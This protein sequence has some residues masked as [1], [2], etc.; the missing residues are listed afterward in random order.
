MNGM[1]T[2]DNANLWQPVEKYKFENNG[3]SDTIQL[4]K[5]ICKTFE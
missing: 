5:S 3:N 1:V 2:I 4:K